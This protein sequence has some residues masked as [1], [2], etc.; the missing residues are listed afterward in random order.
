MQPQAT[1]A[2]GMWGIQLWLAGMAGMAGMAAICHHATCLSSA[3]RTQPSCRAP[4][5]VSCGKIIST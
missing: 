1:G 4:R 2:C 3:I 5:F